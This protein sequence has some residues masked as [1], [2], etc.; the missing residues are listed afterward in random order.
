MI[1][2]IFEMIFNIVKHSLYFPSS[3]FFDCFQGPPGPPG[4][5]GYPGTKGD[6]GGSGY[7][8]I[9]GDKGCPGLKGSPGKGGS[10]G[11]PGQPGRKGPPGPKGEPSHVSAN[12]TCYTCNRLA[13]VNPNCTLFETEAWSGDEGLTCHFYSITSMAFKGQVRF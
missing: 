9:K 4:S 2:D 5:P 7:P 1:F 11:P 8:G 12:T 3:S 13:W 6:G 10:P